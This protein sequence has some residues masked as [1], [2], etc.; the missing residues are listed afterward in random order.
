M[1]CDRC[2]GEQMTKAGRDRQAR[3]L[4]RCRACGRRRTTRAGS[5]CSGERFPDDVIARAVRHSLRYRRSYADV[6]EWL[7]PE[8]TR[9][10]RHG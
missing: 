1:Q 2:G 4:S 5:A 10:R 6:V 9:A 3:Q 8:G 7:H